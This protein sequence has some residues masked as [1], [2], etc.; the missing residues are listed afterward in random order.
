MQQ[1][2]ILHKRNLFIYYSIAIG[3]IFY[4]AAVIA[5]LFECGY[6]PFAATAILV[7]MGILFCLQIPPKAMRFFLL[8]TWNAL[9]VFVILI[10]QQAIAFYW[11]LFFILMTTIYQSLLITVSVSLWSIVQVAIILFFFFE[12]RDLL[13]SASNQIYT[14]FVFLVC[15]TGFMQILSIRHLWK[16]VEEANLEKERKLTSTEAY[17][18]LFFEH[19]EDAI[20]VFDLDDKI[21]EVNPAFE[22]LYG[23]TREECIGHSLPLVPPQNE[24]D[25]KERLKRLLKGERFHLI[26]TQ[27]MKKDGTLFDVQIS[28][29][30]IYNSNGDMIAVSV[31]SRDTS[32]IKE[33]ERLVIQ[34]EKLKVAGEIAAEVAHE[35]RNPMT[36]ISGFMQ[37]MVSDE[38]SPYREYTGLIQSEIERIDTIISDF[39]VLSRPQAD[40]YKPVDIRRILNEVIALFSIEFQNRGIHFSLETD[41]KRTTINGNA[42]HIK[43][44]LINLIKNA[45]EAIDRDG[46]LLIG[47]SNVEDDLCIFIKDSGIGIPAHLLDRIFEPFYTT[48]SKGTGLGMMITN[49]IIKEHQGVI[50]ICSKENAGTEITIRLPL[51]SE[52]R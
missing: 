26:E 46:K 40:T 20:A 11:F 41:G 12:P 35:I 4:F 23:W 38:N 39:L 13:P 1:L 14:F 31:I 25:A 27:D 17:L 47:V 34:S 24:A 52:D 19:A 22:R 32:L 48:K 51:L 16:T 36:V 49:K 10:S 7:L 3:F 37:M 33:N 28:M 45:V 29:S 42:N 9:I 44:V 2:E 30:P 6:Y 8:V 15:A 5:G 43:Q 50:G 18:R 21:I